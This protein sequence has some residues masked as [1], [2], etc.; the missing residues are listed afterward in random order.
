MGESSGMYI[1][2]HWISEMGQLDMFML[3]FSNFYK[4]NS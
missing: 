3:L 2:Y 4:K 1:F